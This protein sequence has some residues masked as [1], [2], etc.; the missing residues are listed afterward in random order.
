ML[1]PWEQ[2]TTEGNGTFAIGRPVL[3]LL[4]DK[5]LLDKMPLDEMTLD[6]M[7][8]PTNCV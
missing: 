8:W 6:K 2:I 1:M 4:L 7:S 5:L 3:K